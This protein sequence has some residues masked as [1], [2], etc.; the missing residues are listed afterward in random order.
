MEI[1]STLV[2]RDF[3]SLVDLGCLS[4]E[5]GVCYVTQF[6]SYTNPGMGILGVQQTLLCL[7]GIV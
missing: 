1:D 3:L 2:N 4:T 5:K 7:S 6:T